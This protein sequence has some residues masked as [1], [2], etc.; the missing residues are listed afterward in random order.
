MSFLHQA[1]DRRPSW[2][3]SWPRPPHAA[4]LLHWPWATG[5]LLAGPPWWVCPEKIN[6]FLLICFNFFGRRYIF[7]RMFYN[8]F[9]LNLF[10]FPP[11]LSIFFNVFPR[12]FHFFL[13]PFIFPCSHHSFHFQRRFS[14]FV[15]FHVSSFLRILFFLPWFY[16]TWLRRFPHALPSRDFRTIAEALAAA[17]AGAVITLLP[18]RYEGAQDRRGAQDYPIS[19]NVTPLENAFTWHFLCKGLCKIWTPNLII[20]FVE[21]LGKNLNQIQ[22]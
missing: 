16:G 2:E 20:I 22:T 4:Q 15:G 3:A 14:S 17:P 9:E 10:S 12:F 13:I 8:L 21:L 6:A 1:W 7:H 19:E 5:T 18:G 11:I